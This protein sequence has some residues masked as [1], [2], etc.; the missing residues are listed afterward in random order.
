MGANVN[1]LRSLESH[2]LQALER[3]RSLYPE[4]RPIPREP[5]GGGQKAA[6][7]TARCLLSKGPVALIDL[8]RSIGWTRIKTDEKDRRFTNAKRALD[9]LVRDG[10]LFKHNEHVYLEK[11]EGAPGAAPAEFDAQ[12]EEV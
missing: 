3:V 4:S 2:L 1:T 8:A 12:L 10:Y 5:R 6:L 7:N 9:S 11:P